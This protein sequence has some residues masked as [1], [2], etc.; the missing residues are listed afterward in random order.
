MSKWILCKIRRG[1]QQ[2]RL[3]QRKRKRK[4]KGSGVVEKE[5]MKKICRVD[6][7]HLQKFTFETLKMLI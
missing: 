2:V 5:G 1:K 7:Q 3:K 6:E 4:R